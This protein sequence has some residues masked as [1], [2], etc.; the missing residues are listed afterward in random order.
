[1]LD[2][3]GLA[4]CLCLMAMMLTACAS[5]ARQEAPREYI[6]VVVTPT[7]NEDV[8]LPVVIEKVVEVPVCV[9]IEK[10]VEVEVIREV[11]VEV[12]VPIEVVREVF[13]QM[14]T[15]TTQ[16]ENGSIYTLGRE[17]ASENEQ[18]IVRWIAECS[19]NSYLNLD[20]PEQVI[21]REVDEVEAEM[22]DALE[23]G[24]HSSF[25]Q[26]IGLSFRLC[27]ATLVDDN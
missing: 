18:E 27:H 21:E 16:G 11:E 10:I 9:G 26:F 24:Q 12:E 4:I 20:L 17:R 23:I 13:V 15:A 5:E 14:P 25:E 6:V 1:M 8:S 3:A 2:K 7:A 22:W 19:A